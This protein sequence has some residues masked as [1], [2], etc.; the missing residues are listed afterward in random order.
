L[1]TITKDEVTPRQFKSVSL[2]CESI[3]TILEGMPASVGLQGSVSV[4]SNAT[5]E[6]FIEVWLVGHNHAKT[7]ACGANFF[8]GD[9]WISACARY[10]DGIELMR[11]MFGDD[12]AEKMAAMHKNCAVV[13]RKFPPHTRDLSVSW[14]SYRYPSKGILIDCCIREDTDGI[15]RFPLTD[16]PP[17][18]KEGSIVVAPGY[19]AVEYTKK[20]GK[21]T[22]MSGTPKSDKTQLALID[23]MTGEIL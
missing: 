18:I 20:S 10:G 12:L 8:R 4:N 2:Y 22:R 7:S 9:M 1:K 13:S 16:L 11:K 23:T 19:Y 15:Q 5:E 3:R 6:Q 21:R 14:N 17:D